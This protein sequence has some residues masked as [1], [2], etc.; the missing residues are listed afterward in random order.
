MIRLAH[1]A[2]AALLAVCLGAVT[3]A[4]AQEVPFT[5]SVIDD[6]VLVRSGAGNSFYVVGELKKDERVV[7]EEVMYGW[8]KVKPPQGVYSYISKAFVDAYGEGDEGKVNTHRAA[9]RAASTNG[10]GESYRRQID[11]LKGATVRILDENGSFYKI[12]PP[13]GAYVFLPPGSLQA[14]TTGTSNVEAITPTNATATPPTPSNSRQAPS[15]DDTPP[16]PLDTQAASHG[17]QS[18]ESAP[19][20]S[21]SDATQADGLQEQAPLFGKKKQQDLELSLPALREL[22]EKLTDTQHLPLEKQP[23]HELLSEYRGL[24]RQPGLTLVDGHVIAMRIAQIRRNLILVDSL[25]EIVQAKQ[26]AVD[27][28]LQQF[29]DQMPPGS[30]GPR[31]D[32]KGELQTSGVYDG[33]NMPRLYRVAKPVSNQIIAYARLHPS[34]DPA[35]FLGKYVGILGQVKYDPALKLE[36]LEVEHLDVI[37]ASAAR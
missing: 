5:A 37:E 33:K 27:N 6:A 18:V 10:P 23:L 4:V 17:D 26:E 1:T 8:Y 14:V 9:V 35:M 20:A 30:V 22:E 7:V 13:D 34:A 31:Y 2:S 25:E 28:P 29:V 11:L 21:Q 3:T 24:G 12:T 32:I 36:V 19:L 15:A 16:S